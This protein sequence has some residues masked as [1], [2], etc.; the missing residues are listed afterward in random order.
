VSPGTATL[1]T[2]SR[3][4]LDRSLAWRTGRLLFEGQTLG[5]VLQE[6]GRYS[7]VE[8]VVND[9]SLRQ[10]EIGGSFPAGPRSADALAQMLVDGFGLRV[11][12]APGRIYIEKAASS[13]AD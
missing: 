12:H 6:L 8:F 3:A 11:R 9:E 1:R 4:E 2:L 7:S 13:T 5:E 10:L